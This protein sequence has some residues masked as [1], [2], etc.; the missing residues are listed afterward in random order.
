MGLAEG[1]VPPL[2]AASA[3]RLQQATPAH[4]KPS[5]GTWLMRPSHAV[6]SACSASACKGGPREQQEKSC[7]EAVPA[8]EVT[9]AEETDDAK[10]DCLTASPADDQVK[11]CTTEQET[12]GEASATAADAAQ[13]VP[14]AAS[15]Q[16]CVDSN[17]DTPATPERKA[18]ERPVTQ[19]PSPSYM[20][21]IEIAFKSQDEQDSD[22]KVGKVE[23]AKEATSSA[24]KKQRKKSKKGPQSKETAC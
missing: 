11:P 16:P 6:S 20:R 14:V 7:P 19:D 24:P 5:V 21:R 22:E 9:S 23:E 13:E 2:E 3:D 15:E 12:A 18:S 8:E 10:E 4:L 1:V 17:V